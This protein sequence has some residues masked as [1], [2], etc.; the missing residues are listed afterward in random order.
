MLPPQLP[1]SPRVRLALVCLALVFLGLGLARSL[2]VP[3]SQGPDEAA[4]FFFTRFVARHGRLPATGEER[5]EAGY[6]A[7]LPPLFYLAAG[8]PGRLIDLDKPPLVK[9]SWNNPRLKL[10]FGPENVKAWRALTTEDPM[11]SEVLLWY[12]ARWATLLAALAGL[13]AAYRL[14]RA[15]RPDQPWLAIAGTALLGCLPGYSLMS[16]VISYEP[17]VGA[18]LAF[19]FLLLLAALAGPG[20][21]RLYAGLGCLAGLAGLTRQTAWPAMLLLPVLLLW[22]ARRQG[23]SWHSTGLRLALAGLGLALTFG[24]WVIHTAFFFNRID[25]LGWPAGFLHPFLVSDGSDTTSLHLAGLL[26]GGR[27]GLAGGAAGTTDTLWQWAWQ[28]FSGIWQPGW[29]AWFFLGL[30]LLALAGLMRRWRQ[31]PQTVRL[32]LVML[33]VHVA[34]FLVLP[35]VRFFFSG[36]ADST[37]SQHILFPAGAAMIVLLVQGLSGWLRPA[38]LAGLLLALA[39]VYLWQSLVIISHDY[40][41]RWPVRTV[42][43]ADQENVL[44]GFETMSLIGSSYQVNERSLLVTLWWRAEAFAAEDYR[45]ELTLLDRRGQ[46]RVRWLGQPLDG[47]YPSRAWSPGDRIRHLVSLPVAGLPAGDYELEL[48]VL[49]A[50]GA[51]VP[52]QTNIALAAPAAPVDRLLLARLTLAPEPAA[53]KTIDLNG[54]KFGYALWPASRPESASGI[55]AIG[56]NA[57]LPLR[58]IP[59]IWGSSRPDSGLPLYREYATIMVLLDPAVNSEVRLSLVGPHGQTHAPADR[60]GNTASFSV[61]PYLASG[62][63]RLR[64]ERLDGTGAETEPLLQIKTAVRQF[65]PGP[66][67]YPL[68]AN[69]AGQAALLG[70]DLPQRR[71]EP[72]GVIP[73]TLHW[74]AIKAMGGDFIIFNHLVDEQRQVWGGQ[75][76]QARDVYTTMLWAPG[77]IV[78]DGF[79]VQVRPDTPD[80]IYR[81]LV[82]LYLPVGQAPV[83]LPLLKEGQL[84]EDTSVSLKPVKVGRTPAGLTRNTANARFVLDQPFGEGPQLYLIGYD[85]QPA[86]GGGVMAAKLNLVLYWRCEATPAVD[87]TT[88]VHVRN[89]AGDII[90]QQDQPPLAGA[91]PT[92]L[93]DPGEIIA[94]MITVPLPKNVAPGPYRLVVGMYEVETGQRLAVP[95]Q[96]SN[97]VTLIDVD[98]P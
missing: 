42:P 11:R 36:Q 38:R 20:P 50:T 17:L 43:I 29:L 58:G 90:A 48:R 33:A 72:G 27:V 4:H 52:A 2:T 92:G 46:P 37:M 55:L 84:T 97:E 31:E 23:W 65:E 14:I 67:S 24:G 86:A 16:G 9:V 61:E 30:W 79:G 80:G 32:W 70:Y 60:T 75:D 93:W 8:L 94:D 10:V 26:T 95:G 76:R 64:F 73:V 35:L 49:G 87:Y 53:L 82:G 68:Q 6:K 54:R 44:A 98:I 83:Y 12:W 81:L 40:G 22:L 25:E 59:K 78:S 28:T 47:R 7:D 41:S 1:A 39:A 3:F 56:T 19:Y 74:Q 96:P 77:E 21:N 15:A 66:I 13:L 89:A 18:L 57:R 51:L 5:R 62:D 85:L 45:L 91:Y 34:I 69:F 88:F 71:V 63:Y